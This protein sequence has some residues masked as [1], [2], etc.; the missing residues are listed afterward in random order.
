MSATLESTVDNINIQHKAQY[1]STA[2]LKKLGYTIEDEN[3][4]NIIDIVAFD[5]ERNCLV[6]VAVFAEEGYAPPVKCGIS[7]K[8]FESAAVDYLKDHPEFCDV[9]VRLDVVDINFLGTNNAFIR[10][11]VNA[12]SDMPADS[13][14]EE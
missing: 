11:Y 2:F 4:C 5:N 6:F 1:A 9:K 3:I 7:R 10:H 12:S 13:S 14:Q 8:V